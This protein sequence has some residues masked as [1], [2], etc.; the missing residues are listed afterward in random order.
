MLELDPWG[1]SGHQLSAHLLHSNSTCSALIEQPR[2]GPAVAK[3]PLL[4]IM[5]LRACPADLTGAAREKWDAL[6]P[7]WRLTHAVTLRQIHQARCRS[8]NATHA[9]TPYEPKRATARHVLRDVKR[10][11][12]QRLEYEYARAAHAAETCASSSAASTKSTRRGAPR[13]RA[14]SSSPT[15]AASATCTQTSRTSRG[16]R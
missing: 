5:G 8:H 12:Q 16:A 7:A 15:R 13:P 1:E 11:V 3:S 9:K 14:R 2:I 4:T 10:R 6:E